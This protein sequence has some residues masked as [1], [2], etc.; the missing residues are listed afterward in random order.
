MKGSVE[1]KQG[2]EIP[3]V[4]FRHQMKLLKSGGKLEE[5][6]QRIADENEQ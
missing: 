3:F 6:R 1:L 4:E 2:L 5:K